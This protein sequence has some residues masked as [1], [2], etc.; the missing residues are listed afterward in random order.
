MGIKGLKQHEVLAV[1]DPALKAYH[2]IPAAEF[3]KQLE[4]LGFTAEDAE[5]KVAE[6][7]ELQHGPKED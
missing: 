2:D 5:K 6:M 1:Y 7:V 3:K 4:S